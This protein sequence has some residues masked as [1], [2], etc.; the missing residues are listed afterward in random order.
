MCVCF[1][2]CVCVCVCVNELTEADGLEF[3]FGQMISLSSRPE[4]LASRRE[5]RFMDTHTL[6]SGV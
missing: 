6:S 1:C 2:V 4:R 5:R 3:V